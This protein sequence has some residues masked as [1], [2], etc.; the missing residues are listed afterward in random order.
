MPPF[1]RPK[2][3]ISGRCRGASSESQR[4]GR[5]QV[6]Y[7][8][9]LQTREQHIR[10]EKA[11]SNICTAQVLLAIMAGM[12]AVYHGPEGLAADR[13]TRSWPCGPLTKVCDNLGSTVGS[14]EFFDTIR[15]RVTQTQ[16]EQI[17]V[18]ADEQGLNLRRYEDDSLGISLDETTETEDVQRL[19]EVFV[20]HARLPFTIRDLAQTVDTAFPANL[21]RTSP[22][23]THEVFNRYHAEH[24]M[25]RYLHRLQARDLSL[26]HSMI[27]LGSCTMKLNATAEMLPVTWPSLPACIRSRRLSRARDIRS[28]FASWNHGWPR[29]RVFPLCRCSPTRDR[30]ASMP[31]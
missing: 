2:K 19:M 24:E 25:L 26:T 8:L 6:A 27:P 12:Y 31:A 5:G 21:A 14:Q 28:C 16:C 20:G 15:V 30:K 7:R 10:R 29:S 4:I 1:F 9:S 11:T 23:L 3:N 13:R 22:Y 17:L 18:R